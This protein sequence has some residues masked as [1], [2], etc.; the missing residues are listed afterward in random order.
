MNHTF[1]KIALC[2]LLCF[3]YRLSAQ[4]LDASGA[5]GIIVTDNCCNGEDNE[6]YQG[7]PQ[8]YTIPT[9][10]SF[11]AIRFFLKGGDGGS[12]KAGA[13]C[14]SEGGDGATVSAFFPVGNESNQLKPGGKI[15]FIVGKHGK[16][17]SSSGTNWAN[18]GG[19]GGTAVLYQPTQNDDWVI[20]A[21]A[22]GGSGAYQGNVFGGCVDS[23]KGSGGRASESGENGANGDGGS[24]GTNGN[25]GEGGDA[26]GGGGAFSDGG[27]GEENNAD[28]G[29]LGYPNGGTGGKIA[30]GSYEDGGGWG[31]GGGG[32]G[33][34]GG[35]GGG[36]YS[37]GGGGGNVDNGGGGGSYINPNFSVTGEKNNG[38]SNDPTSNGH[39]TY[40][41]KNICIAEIASIEEVSG[42]CG[43]IE[44]GTEIQVH[45]NIFGACNNLTYIVN[46]FLYSASNNTGFFTLPNEGNYSMSLFTNING[47]PTLLDV[48]SFS[49]SIDD[50]TPPKAICKNTTVNLQTSPQIIASFENSIDNGSTDNCEITSLTASRNT[51]NCNDIGIVTVTLAATDAAGHSSSCTASVTVEDEGAPIPNVANLPSL[52][53]ECSLSISTFPTATDLCEETI[54]GTTN[55]P[56]TY[57]ELGTYTI[58]WFYQ[59]SKGNTS[60]QTQTVSVYDN[61]GPTAACPDNITVDV[62]AGCDSEPV[63]YYG[64]GLDNCDINVKPVTYTGNSPTVPA[65]EDRLLIIQI[66]NFGGDITGVTYNGESMTQAIYQ[67]ADEEYIS[68]ELWYLT[69]GTGD[70]I[71]PTVEVMGLTQDY[72]IQYTTYAHV[73][74][75]APIDDKDQGFAK[76]ILEYYARNN[77]LVYEGRIRAQSISM[78]PNLNQTEIFD[79]QA[80]PSYPHF[81]WAAYQSASEGGGSNNRFSSIEYITRALLVI[82]AN[83]R[84]QYSYTIP[85]GS[86][87]E[88][89]TTPVT[90]TSTD[91]QNNSSSCSFTVTVVDDY[92]PTISCPDNMTVNTIGDDADLCTAVVTYLVSYADNCGTPTLEQLTGLPSGSGF[93]IGT[94]LNTF[95]VTDGAG[96]T[97][98]CSFE[99]IVTDIGVPVA[100]CQDHT[101]YLN[102]FGESS[103]TTTDIDNSSYDN[104]TAIASLSLDNTSFNCDYLGTNT[105]VLTA[106]DESGSSATCSATV[107]VID[108]IAPEPNCQNHT[109]YL[110][111]NGEGSIATTDIN[112]FSADNCSTIASFSLDNSSFTC[113]HV[114]TNTVILTATDESGNSS[115]CSAT[116]TVVDNTTPDALCQDITLQLDDNGLVSFDPEDIDNGSDDACGIQTLSLDQD[117]FICNTGSATVTLFV[118]DNHGNTSQCTSTATI[119]DPIAPIANCNDLTI[120]LVDQNTYTLSPADIDAIAS[121]SQDNCGWTVAI[122]SG[123]TNYDCDDKDTNFPVTLTVTDNDGNSSSCDANVRVEDPSS[124]CNEAPVAICQDI[125]VAVDATCEAIVE[126]AAIDGGSSDPNDDP[127]TLS[128]DQG[129]G[130]GLG[131]HSVTL[132]VSDGEYTSNCAA[133]IT[134]GDYSLPEVVCKNTTVTFNGETSIDL[135]VSDIWDEA[136]SYDNCGSVTFVGQDILSVTCGQ[137]GQTIPVT[138]IIEDAAGNEDICIA[139][140]TIEGLP[141]GWI[142]EPN[143]LG[144]APGIS[145]FD[146]ETQVFTLSSEGCYDPAYYRPSDHQGFIQQALCGDGQIT[147]QV[148]EVVGN[149]W[150]GISMRESNDPNAAMIQL[151]IDGVSMSRRELRQTAGRY[152][153][154]HM[155]STNDKNWLR[156]SRT[157]NQFTASR[158]TDGVTWEHVFITQIPMSNCIEVGLITINGA[159]SGEVSSTFENVAISGASSLASA[160]LPGAELDVAEPPLINFSIYPNPANDIINLKSE[161]WM[162]KEVDIRIFNQIGQV[163]KAIQWDTSDHLLQQVNVNDLEPGIYFVEIGNDQHKSIKKLVISRP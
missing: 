140:V 76:S 141:C 44:N 131:S 83:H 73:N 132:T 61:S 71:T 84:T 14:K 90:F 56:L 23:Q 86:I 128:M 35:G 89:G 127:L 105:V 74:Q 18:G 22:G 122:T 57:T 79:Q 138:V 48:V 26:G 17:A 81:A 19:G 55:D 143:G 135:A 118:K 94:T 4:E 106:T 124:V 156:L 139:E 116:V 68:L 39:I 120:N 96:L 147:A 34:T 88:V 107:T 16:D 7:Q 63:N 69:L 110:D 30:S 115:T 149:G 78:T 85:P 104:C 98:S 133:T 155:F 13:D 12:A 54:T 10:V 99:V 93:P 46:Q 114:G 38:G 80:H 28:G 134:A 109:V 67:T 150:A 6:F 51:F 117:Y 95:K 64:I 11:N 163:M 9:T 21:V 1:F 102:A 108:H 43:V 136:A 77:D 47:E 113:D 15:R 2:I 5:L 154:A 103:I 161:Q 144:C 91:A 142:V 158:S 59:D 152:A 123:I 20:L 130:F 70:T 32:A 49:V 137:I 58:T 27:P 33:F 60:T 42:F 126:A 145:S 52:T 65:G 3:S 162:D 112:D 75:D 125:T 157:G 25:G 146:S 100:N 72:S 101:I 148:T 151:M 62:L 45:T 92:K 29:S 160:K 82:Q 153:F 36:G 24:G 159:V 87:F 50:T 121:G 40:Q 53:G 97:R 41:F 31:F 119:E 8:D 129:P 111:A 37:G 66:S